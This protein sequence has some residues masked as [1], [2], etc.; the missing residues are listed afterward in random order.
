MFSWIF[1]SQIFF[2]FFLRPPNPSF[3]IQWNGFSEPFWAEK[4]KDSLSWLIPKPFIFLPFFKILLFL[5]AGL[6]HPF[7]DGAKKEECLD[8]QLDTW[9]LEGC[10]ISQVSEG[11][12]WLRPLQETWGPIPGPSSI[13]SWPFRPARS[14]SKP[15]PS[16]SGGLR[17]W[18]IF[19]SLPAGT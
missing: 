10:P 19:P 16:G 3:I 8:Q 14:G 12:L 5:S 15:F 2:W 7:K 18:G 4:G 13:H 17:C 11:W 1:I 9:D 6:T